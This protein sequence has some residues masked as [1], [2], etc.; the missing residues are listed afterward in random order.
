[1][2]KSA[3]PHLACPDCAGPISL[4][5]G[6][7]ESDGHVMAGTLGC[8]GCESSFPILRGIP[9]FAGVVT[10]T[11][12]RFGEQWKQFA[13]MAS[14]QEE[15]LRA[16]LQPVAPDD[17]RGKLVYEAG[18]GK[19]RHTVVVAGWGAKAVIA[20]DLGESVEVAFEHTRAVATAHVIQGDL[21][22]PPV[23]RVFDVAFSIG[24]L[25]HLPDPR[26]G[27]DAVRGRVRKGGKLAVWVY[28]RENNEW[29]VRFVDPV[30]ERVTARLPPRALYWLS[31]PPSA[32]LAAAARLYR[33]GALA[34]RL[35]YRD[36]A[37][38]LAGLPLREVHNIVY[39]QLVTPVAHYLLED[40]VREWLAAP[41]LDDVTLAWHNK[42]SWRASA[43]VTG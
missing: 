5:E 38:R 18:C 12:G 11:A 41:G 27:F 9:R 40:E 1:M 20:L 3:L 8:S 7:E 17:V 10:E 24:V 23:K 39:D 35:P 36:Y 19:G 21:L 43:T 14:Y 22:R 33:V 32:A 25:H 37:R 15:W 42:N 34:E 6:R 31:L 4:A 13:H 30:R 29:I 26:A 28:G 2:R 16:W